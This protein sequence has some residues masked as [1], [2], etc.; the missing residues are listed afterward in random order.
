MVC[1]FFGHRDCY[2]LDEK[3]LRC[4]IEELIA[5]GVDTFYVGH[6]GSFDSLVLEC[7]K[8]LKKIY[9][10]IS[11]TVILAYLPTPGTECDLYDGMSM[12][13]EIEGGPPRFAIERRNKWMIDKATH[14]IAFINRTYGGAYKFAKRAKR[15]GLK[16]TN[17]GNIQL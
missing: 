6:Q 14:C 8:H 3:L 10:H 15:K 2:G 4:A 1:T 17:L 7:L 12:Y 11:Y 9:E 13:P 16:V 5:K